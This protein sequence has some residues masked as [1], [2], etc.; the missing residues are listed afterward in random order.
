[1]GKGARSLSEGYRNTSL[2]WTL[3]QTIHRALK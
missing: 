3:P 2:E 1:M